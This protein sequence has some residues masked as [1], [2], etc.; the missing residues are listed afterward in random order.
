MRS[1]NDRREVRRAIKHFDRV[2]KGVLMV[3]HYTPQS[4]A[5][6]L[7][8]GRGRDPEFQIDRLVC[9]GL[10]TRLIDD[11]QTQPCGLCG[12]TLSAD[13]LPSR[14]VIVRPAVEAIMAEAHKA[15]ELPVFCHL[16]CDAC[17]R[18]P[19]VVA[20]VRDYIAQAFPGMR[21][22]ALSPGVGHA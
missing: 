15:D 3:V 19:D 5:M 21:P 14:I 13:S 7:L 4:F 12:A 10:I 8:M 18:G 17:E 22:L 16:I 9:E 6:G 20:R 1:P 11:R 2:A